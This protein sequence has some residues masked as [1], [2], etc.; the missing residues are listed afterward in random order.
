MRAAVIR[1]TAGQTEQDHPLP[2]VVDWAQWC[3]NEVTDPAAVRALAVDLVSIRARVPGPGRQALAAVQ[4]R[5][6]DLNA[7]PAGTP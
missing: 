2:D 5:L 7:A 6:A 4:G 1:L 3:W